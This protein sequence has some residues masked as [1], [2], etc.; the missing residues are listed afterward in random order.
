MPR[1][2]LRVTVATLGVALCAGLATALV[3]CTTD[4]GADGGEAGDDQL[5][6]PASGACYDLSPDDV[7]RDTNASGT[8]E[9][10]ARHTAET[11]AAGDLPERFADAD[12]DAD[13]LA[14]WVHEKCTT[15]FEK[16]LRADES[17]AMRT[18]LSWVWFQPTD[19]AWEAGARWFRCDLVGGGPGLDGYRS[20]PESTVGLLREPSDAWMLCSDG[21]TLESGGLV[22]CTEDHRWRAV[23]T[24]KVVPYPDAEYPGDEEVE[25]TTQDYC[26]DSVNAW[27]G[28]PTE[29]DF[30]YTWFGQDAWQQGNRRSVCWAR[31]QA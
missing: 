8:V 5:T 12:R 6:A 24:I 7:A 4:A 14:A 10:A 26:E 13:A 29:F 18:L 11:I 25:A 28:Y 31:T 3:G 16:H 23:T 9:C 19:A 20:L 1:R 30:A 2:P 15:R 17:T 27:L 22:D 21:E